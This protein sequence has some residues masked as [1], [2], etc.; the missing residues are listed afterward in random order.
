MTLVMTR[1][2]VLTMTLG[3]STPLANFSAP[4]AI[5]AT[6]SVHAVD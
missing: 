2:M 3:P 1:C 6:T 5:S 4:A